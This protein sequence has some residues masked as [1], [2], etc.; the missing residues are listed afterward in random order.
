MRQSK[1]DGVATVF[2]I[3]VGLFL[4]GVIL[5]SVLDRLTNMDAYTCQD[6]AITAEP[7]DDYW[8]YAE[9]YCEG[10]IGHVSDDLVVAYGMPLQ[11]GNVV[12]LPKSNKCEIFLK[13]AQGQQYAYEVCK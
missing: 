5:M 11:V 7:G 2:L 12:Y 8:G 4:A 6:I 3:V 1:I 13:V 9:K 10:S